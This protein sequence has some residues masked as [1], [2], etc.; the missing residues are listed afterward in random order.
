MRLRTW[1]STSSWQRPSIR[2][3]PVTTSRHGWPRSSQSM[4]VGW[5]SSDGRS[6]W[7]FRR[8]SPPF[9]SDCANTT[10]TG[11]PSSDDE[12]ARHELRLE[13]R[14]S[15]FGTSDDVVAALAD[16]DVWIDLDAGFVERVVEAVVGE[17]EV[18][19]TTTSNSMRPTTRSA[20]R[21]V[22]GDPWAATGAVRARRCRR[23]AVRC[24][25]RPERRERNAGA[26][27]LHR[28]IDSDRGVDRR[29][30]W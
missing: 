10:S 5:T 14:L 28:R 22:T 25:H 3:P 17:P 1:R 19:M 26:T 24:D 2:F 9:A 27:G 15:H 8:S 18:A 6:P 13:R 23:R 30:R 12:L 29:R 16:P 21:G 4:P 20:G 11:P 7:R